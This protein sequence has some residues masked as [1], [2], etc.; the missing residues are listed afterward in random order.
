MKQTLS[1]K[2]NKKITT[3]SSGGIDSAIILYNIKKILKTKR[4]ESF[5]VAFNKKYN[6]DET[7]NA[8]LLSKKFADKHNI[9]NIDYKDL[10]LDLKDMYNY[11]DV[12]VS[13]ASIYG[14]YFLNKKIAKRKKNLII[15]GYAGNNLNAGFYPSYL[16]NFLDI[17]NKRILK[18]EIDCWIKLHNTK[19]NPKS[20]KLFKNFT[21]FHYDKKIKGKILDKI[22]YLT[23]KHL[24]AKK[25]PR[26]KIRKNDEL[27]NFGNY[28]KKVFII[29]Q[30]LMTV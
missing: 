4:F 24:L 17:Q 10:I 2:N 1:D 25:I 26:R 19:K 14:Y 8:K 28:L 20:L 27:L 13:T 12:P 18:D 7:D 6:Y 22:F 11:L 9:I 29:T 16:F 15:S 5:T 21:N 3:S 23:K 30:F